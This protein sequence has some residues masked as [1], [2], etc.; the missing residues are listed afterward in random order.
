VLRWGSVPG[1]NTGYLP[2]P[3][4]PYLD[5]PIAFTLSTGSA[6]TTVTGTKTIGGVAW[7]ISFDLTFTLSTSGDTVSITGSDTGRMPSVPVTAQ[8]SYPDVP[9]QAAPTGRCP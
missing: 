4:Q 1:T 7:T 3:T 2:D 6:H 5:M 8:L 9:I